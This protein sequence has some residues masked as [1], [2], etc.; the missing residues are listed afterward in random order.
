MMRMLKAGA[1]Y[2]ALVFGAG[3]VL[4]SI[5]LLWLVP[6]FGTRMAELMEMPILLVVIIVAAR[7]IIRRLAVPATPSSRLGMGCFALGLLL[8][9][10][11]TLVLWLRGLS[12]SEYFAGRDPVSGTIYYVMLGVFAVMPFFVARI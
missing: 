2:F 7:W 1:L 10:E 5:R 6:R 8:A 9:A 3:F 11:F 4:G 12:I